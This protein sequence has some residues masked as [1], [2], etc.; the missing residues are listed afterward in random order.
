MCWPRPGGGAAS[1]NRLMAENA[2]VYVFLEA[3]ARPGPD[4]LGLM[5]DALNAKPIQFVN[6][7]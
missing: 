6:R 1:F 4:W 2:K 3:G 7:P 5:L